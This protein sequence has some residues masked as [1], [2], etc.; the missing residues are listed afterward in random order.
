MQIIVINNNDT[1]AIAI[2]SAFIGYEGRGIHPY[3]AA[4]DLIDQIRSRLN[5]SPP[6]IESNLTVI[7]RYETDIS[8][9]PPTEI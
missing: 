5:D 3:T 8:F 7:T 1:G 9:T 4:C 2:C 6:S